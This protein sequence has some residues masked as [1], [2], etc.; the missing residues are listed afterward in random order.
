MSS[1]HL[2]DAI[3]LAMG[4]PSVAL[5]VLAGLLRLWSLTGGSATHPARQM[6]SNLAGYA[7]LL[8]S[9]SLFAGAYAW[10]GQ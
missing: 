6:A 4:L 3:G 1:V 8:L 10:A 9:C 5:F 2:F 7:G